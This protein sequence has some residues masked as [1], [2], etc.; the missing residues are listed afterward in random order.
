MQNPFT[1]IKILNPLATAGAG[2][3]TLTSDA[4]DT[5]GYEGIF[6]L[7]KFGTAAADN[8]LKAQQSSDD[9]DADAYADLAGTQVGVGASDELVWLRIHR[10]RE[11][12]V[13]I[14]A[15]RGT[16]TTLDAL[17]VFA[18]G[19]RSQPVDNTVAGTIHGESHVSPAEGTA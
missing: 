15:L 11:R 12:Y 10:P 1:D 8:T 6:V 17:F 18:Y 13:K 2:T 5:A 7:A 14:L 4:I 3:S 19:A 16:S 9:G